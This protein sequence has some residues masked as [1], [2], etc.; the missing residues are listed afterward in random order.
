MSG[1]AAT[2]LFVKKIMGSGE[3]CPKCRDVERRLRDDGLLPRV[4]RVVVAREDDP[5]SPG[6]RLARRHAVQRAPFFV[7]RE[8]D[9]S[10]R[11]IESYLAFKRWFS[12]AESSA[13]EL[14][15]A[16]DRHPELAFT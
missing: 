8:P 6:A 16:V 10:E 9:G 4:D 13:G 5:D 12:S 3:P 1:T 11:V 14:A 2:V 15:D 7:L